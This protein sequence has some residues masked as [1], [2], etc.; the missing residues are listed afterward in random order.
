MCLLVFIPLLVSIFVAAAHPT[1]EVG[2]VLMSC[3]FIWTVVAAM[4]TVPTQPT[5]SFKF[6]TGPWIDI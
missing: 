6:L 1:L 3:I 5:V 2:I 4:W